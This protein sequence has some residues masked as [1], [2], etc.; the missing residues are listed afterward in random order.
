MAAFEGFPAGKVRFTRIPEQFFN[1]LLPQIDHLGELKIVLY[2]LWRMSRMEGAFRYL[3]ETDFLDDSLFMEGLGSD[4]EVRLIALRDALRR[5]V[6]RGTILQVTIQQRDEEIP[7]YFTNTSKGR[8]AVEAV[9]KGEWRPADDPRVPVELAPE[10]PTIYHLYEANIGPVTPLLAE[11]LQEA[12]DTYPAQ[13]VEDAFRVA[14]ERNVR[15]W[16]YVEAILRRWQERGRDGRE[17]RRDTEK[18]RQRYA[19]WEDDQL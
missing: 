1:E 14:V 9:Q 8:A 18:S 12:E 11:A 16:R 7:I 10:R 2:V 4:P 17:D 15:N 3:V 19:E 6:E 5:S 13:W